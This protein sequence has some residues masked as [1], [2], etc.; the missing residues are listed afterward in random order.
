MCH[1]AHAPMSPIQIYTLLWQ[2][3]HHLCVPLSMCP[4]AHV[5]Y[6]PC[7]PLPYSH[8]DLEGS[9]CIAHM[10]HHSCS[11]SPMCPI[12]LPLVLM[13]PIAHA[14]YHPCPPSRSMHYYGSVP[15][16]HVSHCPC[17]PLLMCPITHV[18]YPSRCP[19]SIFSINQDTHLPTCPLAY[20]SKK[21]SSCQKDV[22]LSKRCEMSKSQTHGLWRRF[23]KK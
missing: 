4:I 6:C 10:P 3:A 8:V 12:T 13:W 11:P 14:P 9:C 18:P 20:M 22:K 5:A 2:C 1:I 21:M 7:A 16:H 17:V 19:I 23:T 15:H